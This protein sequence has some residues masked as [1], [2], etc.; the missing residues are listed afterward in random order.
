ADARERLALAQLCQQYKRLYAA[1]AR[2]YA[3]AFAADPTLT[4]DPRA[5]HRYHAA[6]AASMAAVG[7]GEDAAKLDVRERGRL[8]GQG[9]AWLRADL[10]AW[11]EHVEKGTPQER[12]EAAK[13]LRHW[14]ADPDLAGVRGPAALAK[15]PEPERAAW[16][17]LWADVQALLENAG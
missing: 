3:G 11:A 4:D 6:R 9:L 1:S 2:F 15:L 12:A 7:K 13:V 16:T 10:D 5:P 8:R 14:Q 17:R